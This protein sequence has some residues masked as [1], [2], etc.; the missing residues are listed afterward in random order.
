[1]LIKDIQRVSCCMNGG[2]F[3]LL[4][5]CFRTPGVKAVIVFRFGQW[6]TRQ[7]WVLRFLLTPLY[8]ILRYRIMTNWGI[9]I[10]REASIGPGLC[11]GHFGGI[12]ISP[13]ARI[14]LNLDISQG[15][16][17]G[18]S[19]EGLDRGAP[20]LGDNV[21]IGPGAKVFGKITIGNN[22][23]IGAN[24]VVYKSIPDNAIVVLKPGFE[25]LSYESHRAEELA[26]RRNRT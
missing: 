2:W 4:V 17:I 21:Y 5:T 7:A 24:A 3:S 8:H 16:T 1:M 15:V 20:T 6:L 13:G 19:G 18:V 12:I 23:K 14:G 26:A 9:D 10:P 11:V 22:A 25:I